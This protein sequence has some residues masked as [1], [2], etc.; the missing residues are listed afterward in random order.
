MFELVFV[1]V[2]LAI[3]VMTGVTALTVTLA[4]AGSFLVMVML[5]MIGVMLQ[6]L[7]Y[8]LAFLIA[9]WI[10]KRFVAQSN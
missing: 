1:L 6:L 3:L 9:I 8:V 10:Y 2:F 7:P 4:I 5:G